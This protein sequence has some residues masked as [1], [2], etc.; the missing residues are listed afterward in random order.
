MSFALEVRPARLRALSLIFCKFVHIAS[1][2]IYDIGSQPLYALA[3]CIVNEAIVKQKLPQR[4]NDTSTIWSSKSYTNTTSLR[5]A[6][7]W[8]G[9]APKT[10]AG[11]YMI[12]R[13]FLDAILSSIFFRAFQGLSAQEIRIVR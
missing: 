3:H 7:Q 6:I 1:G 10:R 4:E 9:P 13:A 12:L 11:K 5:S 8:C 2:S